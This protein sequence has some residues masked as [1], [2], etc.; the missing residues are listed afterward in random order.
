[1]FDGRFKIS[2]QLAVCSWQN[3][4]RGW[5]V[6]KRVIDRHSVVLIRLTGVR[7]ELGKKLAIGKKQLARRAKKPGILSL[8]LLALNTQLSTHI[9][10][11]RF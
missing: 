9:D 3:K 5:Q 10:L 6:N 11:T 2:G 1:M 7:Q 4:N 8:F